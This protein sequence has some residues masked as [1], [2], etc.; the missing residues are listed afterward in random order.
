M[1]HYLCCCVVRAST[2][3]SLSPVRPKGLNNLAARVPPTYTRSHNNEE[4]RMAQYRLNVNGKV[5]EVDAWDGEMPLLYALRNSLELHAAKFGCGLGQCG[6]CTVLVDGQAVRSCTLKISD[7]VGKRVTTNEGLGTPDKPHPLQAA[8]IADPIT[9][10]SPVS[11]G[12]VTPCCVFPKRRASISNSCNALI[13]RRWER[14][15]HP[16]PRFR[17]RSPMRC[18]MRPECALRRCPLRRPE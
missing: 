1:T 2:G 18:L 17:P 10:V 4:S 3:W 6:T 11:I 5:R 14:V 8:F 13:S 16:R 15:K 12:P 7:A 9:A